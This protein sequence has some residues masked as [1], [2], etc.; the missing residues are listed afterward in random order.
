MGTD[1]PI[2]VPV[3]IVV[4]LNFLIDVPPGINV[5]TN[6]GR[7]LSKIAYELKNCKKWDPTKKIIAMFVCLFENSEYDVIPVYSCKSPSVLDNFTKKNSCRFLV[8]YTTVDH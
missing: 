5:P 6:L 8:F 3:P 1:P 4:T 7:L 2:A